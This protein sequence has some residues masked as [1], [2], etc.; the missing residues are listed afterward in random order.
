LPTVQVLIDEQ[1]T[2]V[3]KFLEDVVHHHL[4]HF[5]TVCEA[6]EHD[7]GFNSPLFVQQAAFHPSPSLIQTLLYPQHT[8]SLVKY[9]ALASVTSLTIS[10]IKGRG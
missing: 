1:D 5:W 2:L 9:F 6:E 7:Q 4:E 8:S 3:Y 10:G